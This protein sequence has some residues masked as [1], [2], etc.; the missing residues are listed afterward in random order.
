M[1]YSALC[2]APLAFGVVWIDQVAA[3]A[4]ETLKTSVDPIRR[5]IALRFRSPGREWAE[6]DMG[7]PPP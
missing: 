6:T 7:L 2:S 5:K 1:S 3:D 4:D